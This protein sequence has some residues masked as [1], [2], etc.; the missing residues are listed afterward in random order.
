MRGHFYIAAPL[1]IECEEGEAVLVTVVRGNATLNTTVT[2][3][4]Q[5]VPGSAVDGDYVPLN[6]VEL[7]FTPGVAEQSFTV[8]TLQDEEAEY[9]ETFHLRLIDA[10]GI[11]TFM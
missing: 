2:V 7:V 1:L 9:D 3:W 8:Q 4:Y 6:D 11:L 5:T 10:T